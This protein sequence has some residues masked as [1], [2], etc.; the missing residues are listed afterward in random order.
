MFEWLKNQVN[1]S[2]FYLC[3]GVCMFKLKTGNV[4]QKLNK[5][6]RKQAYTLAAIV[7]VCFIALLSLASFLGG[8]DDTSFDGMTTRG[9]D[10]A[11][12]PFVND[13][14]ESYLLASKY[15]D[16]QNNG[17]SLLYSP[18]EKEARQEEDAANAEEDEESTSGSSGRED[19]Y[20]GG[21]YGG[22]GYGSGRGGSGGSTTVGQLG[23]ASV[24]GAGGSGMTGTFG[25]PR[26]DFSPYKSQDKGT[27]IAP[28]LK[29]TDAKKA[30][31]QFAQTS[32]AAAGLKDGKGGNAKKALMGGNIKGSEAFT[33]KGVDLS[34]SGGLAL[35]TNAPVTSADLS[36]LE[37][38]LDDAAKEA[39]EENDQIQEDMWDRLREQLFSGMI[40]M[41][42]NLAGQA[43]SNLLDKAMYGSTTKAASKEVMQQQLGATYDPKNPDGNKLV[44]L[45]LC[46]S[47]N[48]TNCDAY[49]TWMQGGTVA[50]AA[51]S[52]GVSNRDMRL[53]VKHNAGQFSYGKGTLADVYNGYTKQIGSSGT[54]NGDPCYGI[55]V[56]KTIN[57]GNGQTKKC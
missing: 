52:W 49:K 28:Q 51:K 4:I 12:M 6:D 53:N 38:K 35:D 27:E 24:K 46:G 31:S 3:K 18:E 48:T 50:D 5:M 42:L 41:V 10:L 44:Q 19:S 57:M 34:K 39:K 43:A 26:G 7:V 8:A 21:G 36:N 15:P 20:S 9:Y 45:Q 40:N 1:K 56:G 13:E 30:L 33:D 14:A 32:R 29:N 17:S 23:Q 2:S 25:A 55:E 22:R 47:T 16:M 54:G 11:Q 37:D